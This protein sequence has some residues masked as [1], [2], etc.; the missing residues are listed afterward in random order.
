MD[1]LL[2]CYSP[3]K[4]GLPATKQTL[5][6]WIVDAIYIS[7][8]SSQLPSQMGVRTHSNRTVVAS[9]AFLAGVPIQCCGLVH[10]PDLRQVLWP[11]YAGHSRLFHSLALVVLLWHTHRAGAWKSGSVGI[12]FPKA[13]TGRSSSS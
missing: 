6:R 2:V 11:R 3:L 4:S 10:I 7:F 8:E 1:Q 12:S 13:S 9:K 5:S